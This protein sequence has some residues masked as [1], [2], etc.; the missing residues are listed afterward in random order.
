MLAKYL[1]RILSPLT[2]N[3]F[4]I[5]NSF[6]FAEEVVNYD[7][8]FCMANLNVE[9]YLRTSLWK[10]LLRTVS[11]ICSPVIFIVVN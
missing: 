10:K 11:A 3:E 8:N 2:T 4:T 1:N 5:K 6:D 9:R 7:H